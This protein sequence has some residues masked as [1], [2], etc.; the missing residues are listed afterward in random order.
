[1]D[2]AVA[3]FERAIRTERALGLDRSRDPDRVRLRALSHFDYGSA[4]H[5]SGREDDALV[6]LRFAATEDSGNATYL[7]TLADACLVRGREREG[8]SL[9][10][11]LATLVGG[12]GEALVSRGWQAARDGQFV[13][14]EDL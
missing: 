13:E 6:W 10:R 9:L 14:A 4:L 11:R 5:R 1:P 8:D 2:L 7:R 3:A 12:E